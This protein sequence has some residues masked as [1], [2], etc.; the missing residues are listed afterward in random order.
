MP[1]QRALQQIH[2]HAAAVDR[3]KGFVGA[4]ALQV[5]G[6]R[7]QFFAGAAFALN[8]NR[9][10]ARGHLRYKIQN[11]QNLFTLADDVAVAK[12]FLQGAPQLKVFA[13]QLALFDR[14]AHDD[15]EASR[16]SRAW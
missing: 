11:F 10:A 9:A 1:K 6:F 2:R 5:D 12:A 15:D 3:H 14:I 16:C 7:D 8:K 4:L 13:H